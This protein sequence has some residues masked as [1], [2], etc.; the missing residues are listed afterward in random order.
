MVQKA[1]AASVISGSTRTSYSISSQSVQPKVA[2]LVTGSS[3][4]WSYQSALTFLS[5]LPADTWLLAADSEA[6]VSAENTLLCESCTVSTGKW[7]KGHG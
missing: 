2:Q 4:P 6:A 5:P 7:L 3:F 1:P